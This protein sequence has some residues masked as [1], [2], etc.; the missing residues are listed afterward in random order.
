MSKY[1]AF[2]AAAIVSEVFGTNMMKASAGF[3]LP[4]ETALFAVG[5]IVCFVFLTFS[6]EGLSLGVAY[7]IW[8]GV[9]VALTALLGVLLWGDPMNGII[10]AGIA[11]IIGGVVLLET[12]QKEADPQG[13]E[14]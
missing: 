11:L 9:G 4:L 13:G 2:L 8:S 3:T 1:Y 7:G 12:S 6:L 14:A 5:Y 10:V